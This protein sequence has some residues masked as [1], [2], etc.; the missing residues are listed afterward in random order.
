MGLAIERDTFTPEEE[1]RFTA[2]LLESLDVL[3]ELLAR[4]GFG[5]GP[6]SVGAE[7]ELNLVDGE[8][9]PLP[10]NREVL[11]R[12]LDPRVT[13]ELNRFNVECN[14][15]PAPLAGRPFTALGRE[16]TSALAEVRRAA[17]AAAPGARVVPVGV[18][19]TLREGDLGAHALTQLPRYRALSTRLRARRGAPFLV[20]IE[21]EEG[22]RLEADDVT[23]EGASTS[24]QFHLRVDPADFAATYN[25]AQLATAPVLALC[26]NAPLFLG[27][28]LW[29]ETRVALFRQ[30]T[31]ARTEQE[32][33]LALPARVTFNSGW[34]RRGAHELFAESVLQHPALLPVLA[35]RGP[36]EAAAAAAGVGGAPPLEE[37]RLHHGTVWSWNRAVYDPA[38]GGHLRV[39]LRALPAGPSVV[40]MLAGGALL[41][42]LT[43]ALSRDVDAL[44]PGI[45]FR[46]ASANFRCAARSGLD[47][48]LVWPGRQPRSP[49]PLPA[50]ELLAR[51][52]P[53]ARQGLLDAGVEGA[54]VDPLF[55]VLEGRLATGRTG[56]AWQLASLDALEARGLS[57]EAALAELLRAYARNCEGGAPVHTWPVG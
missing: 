41:L 44:L 31:D 16:L 18:L 7:L 8:G 19:P 10:V 45:P 56:A 12:T 34:V 48:T 26:G 6:R 22:V 47:A 35:E 57:R 13:V 21:G 23:V 40:D 39:E 52:L 25:A 51:L 43:L 32:E 50:R 29:Q 55:A 37:L 2:R 4:P 5:V 20:D 3:G 42:G 54:D 46:L 24:L 1:A 33:A 14:V 15:R 27:R 38:D 30:A 28:R 11:A 17:E 9:R 53:L 36:R 49:H